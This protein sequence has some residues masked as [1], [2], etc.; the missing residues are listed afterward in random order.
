MEQQRLVAEQMNWLKVKP[1][2]GAISGTKVES[3]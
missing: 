2:G 1:A 3:R